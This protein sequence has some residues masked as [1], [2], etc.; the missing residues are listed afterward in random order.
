[1]TAVGEAEPYV[2]YRLWLDRPVRADRSP[3]YTVSR[4]RYV[5]SLAIYSAF[6]EP[7]QSWARETKGSVIEVHAYAVAPEDLAP[8]T[9]IAE[10]MRAELWRL[11]PELAGATVLHAEYQQQS[12][13]TRWAPGDFATRPTTE[14][15]IGGLLL[16]GDHVKLPIPASLMEAAVVSGRFAANAILVREGVQEVAISTVAEK[17]P[18]G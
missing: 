12:N 15:E 4:Y 10:R 7:Y 1:V 13:F 6:Q 14:T 16:A 18:L 9:V 3:F 11:L 5:D 8:D 2:V 17:G